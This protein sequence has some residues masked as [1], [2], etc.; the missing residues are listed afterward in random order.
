MKLWDDVGRWWA[1]VKML[2]LLQSVSAG[3]QL[4]PAAEDKSRQLQILDSLPVVTQV[5]GGNCIVVVVV[6]VVYFIRPFI[7]AHSPTLDNPNLE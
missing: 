5:E 7:V 2:Q 6:V 4:F 1:S 3:S